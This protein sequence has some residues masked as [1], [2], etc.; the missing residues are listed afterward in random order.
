[1]PVA[2]AC[3]TTRRPPR[4]QAWRLL[5]LCLLP[6]AGG[7]AATPLP[8]SP[9]EQSWV[10]QHP[11]IRYCYSTDRPPY[12]FDQEGH[13]AGVFADY[14]R[15]LSHRL[16]LTPEALHS[17]P[18]EQVQRLAE[19]GECDLV[20]GMVATPK[21]QERFLFTHPFSDVPQVLLAKGD[22]PF[23]PD[24]RVLAGMRVGVLSGTAKARQLP[25]QYPEI[26]WVADD[27]ATLFRRLDD[28]QL[29]AILTNLEKALGYSELS[30]SHYHIIGKLERAHE[31]AIAVRKDWPELVALYDR[32]IA[33]LGTT[34]HNT[35]DLRWNHYVVQGHTDYRLALGVAFG[36]LLLLG[37]FGYWNQRLRR[38]IG[39]RKAT[40][41]ALQRSESR[42]RAIIS[43]E[44]ECI[45][46]LAPDATI[47]EMNPAGS[48]MLGAKS[49]EAVVGHSVYPFIAPEHREAF[50]HM[51]HQVMDGMAAQL[52]FRVTGLS[53]EPRWLETHAVP[54]FDGEARVHLAVTRDI[55]AHKAY[56][57]ALLEAKF[58]AES[59]SR[60]KTTFLTSMSHELR[61]PLNAVL[62][63]AQILAAHAQLPTELQRPVATIQRSGTQ[64]LQLLND[65][66]DLS[67]L[68]AGSLDLFPTPCDPQRLL[69]DLYET[70]LP[71]AEGKGLH[72]TLLDPAPRPV[73]LRADE[74]RL[75]QI[76]I[77]LL[78]NAVRYTA[79]GEVGVGLDYRDGVLTLEVCD[80]GPGIAPERLD[81]LFIPF[82]HSDA[83]PYKQ[84]GVGLGLAVSHALAQKMDG[85]LSVESRLGG[86][87]RF[88]LRVPLALEQTQ[89]HP[90]SAP[91]GPID[92][93]PV[94]HL[95]TGLCR[96]DRRW[97]EGFE[98]A[99][100]NGN[101]RRIDAALDALQGEPA[102][103][104]DNLRQRVEQ[105]D[106]AWILANLERCKGEKTP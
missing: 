94:D 71:Q 1:M 44:P 35:I 36:S 93:R 57:A 66:L 56:E 15:V 4:H 50:A 27:Y 13:H 7:H 53:G 33:S 80:T 29:Y 68:E 85:T 37:L 75:R 89:V 2:S 64:L 52:E 32:A 55:S 76:G 87:S 43:A 30:G 98:Q 90:P 31:V 3:P 16:G 97:R 49:A 100:V 65:V 8:L 79:T 51:H 95:E 26:E 42:L 70:F 69:H 73:T 28:G 63:F 58:R 81:E 6:L 47:L 48:A 11:H 40:D 46:I 67:R 22:K 23:I 88:R 24:T 102:T 17:G 62:G 25:K 77:N 74:R 78:S 82:Q 104:V 60:A 18:W 20:V 38:E 86:G 41:L 99:L 39:A 14:L 84:T 106:Y 72:L 5:V 91:P 101:R 34:D 21:R 10:A 12:D 83:D 92:P 96:L 9:A 54:L 19:A 103:L 59:A 105:F 61:T 45:K